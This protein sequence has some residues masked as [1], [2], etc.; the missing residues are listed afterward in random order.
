M[1]QVT[2]ADYSNGVDSH[3]EVLGFLPYWTKNYQLKYQ[4]LTHIAWFC[5]EIDSNGTIIN[6]G[7]PPSTIIDEAHSQNERVL[8]TAACFNDKENP[9]RVDDMLAGDHSYIVNQLLS[10]VRN[11]NGD[12]VIIDFEFP[13]EDS[14]SLLVSFMRLLNDA[15]KKA[16]PNY[17][18]SICLPAWTRKE[19]FNCAE[20]SNYVDSFFI[21]AYDYDLGRPDAWPVSPLEGGWINVKATLTYYLGQTESWR[22]ILGLPRL[23]C[24][25]RADRENTRA[26]KNHW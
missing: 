26:S 5:V 18:L 1:I 17:Y 20:L 9:H 24:G 12:G 13:S 6:H 14:A 23:D 16:N 11:G 8:L 3:F 10:L 22:F 15:F 4:P 21:M 25:K 19:A 7:W 2:W